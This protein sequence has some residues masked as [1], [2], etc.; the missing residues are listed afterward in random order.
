MMNTMGGI[1][2]NE[3]MEI[4][5]N[6]HNTIPGLYAAGVDTGGWVSDTYRSILPGTAFGFAL[7]SGRIA[8]ENAVKYASGKR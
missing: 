4:I 6:Q 1:K 7:N 3:R 2:I 8:G 5:D